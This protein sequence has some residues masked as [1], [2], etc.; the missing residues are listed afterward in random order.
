MTPV[1]KPITGARSGSK[2]DLIDRDLTVT[3]CNY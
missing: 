1:A 2:T 3:Q